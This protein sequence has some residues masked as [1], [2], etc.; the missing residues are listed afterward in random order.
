MNTTIDKKEIEFSKFNKEWWDL[1]GTCR[2]PQI[3]RL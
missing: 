3:N 1:E 2:P